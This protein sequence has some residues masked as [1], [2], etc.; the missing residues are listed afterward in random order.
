MI[1]DKLRY[2]LLLAFM[3]VVIFIGLAE[4][5]LEICNLDFA[6][7]K[8]YTFAPHF[9]IDPIVATGKFLKDPVLFWR[10]NPKHTFPFPSSEKINSKGFRDREFEI[11][12]GEGICRI[13]CL[14]DSVTFG[15]PDNKVKI[16]QVYSERL[17]ALLNLSFPER[18]FEVI[19]AGVPGYSSYQGLLYLKELLRKGYK[20]DLVTVLFGYDDAA[21]AVFYSDKE[22]HA[23]PLWIIK[24]QNWLINF[25]LYQFLC[26][27]IILPKQ[28]NI[29]DKEEFMPRVSYRE[30]MENINEMVKIAHKSNIEVVCITPLIFENK[31]IVPVYPFQP[32]IPG[33]DLI[34]RL[35]DF[36]G[37]LKDLFF[38]NCHFTPL[39]HQIAAEEIYKALT[40]EGIIG[41]K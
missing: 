38:D 31:K 33:V 3:A 30:Y 27:L 8:R 12:K 23:Q 9:Q 4:A 18:R 15:A 35:K 40:N 29:S 34:Q 21:P 14:G 2:K 20:P 16:E 39:G 13:I 32:G 28:A 24:S 41:T 5:A 7:R 17:E 25:K 19:N 1:E 36:Q 22:Q 11:K 37:D 6:F 10:L 26:N